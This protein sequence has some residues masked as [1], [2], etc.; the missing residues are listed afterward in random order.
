M[1]SDL[2]DILD[3]V[4]IPT[5]YKVGYMSNYYREPSFREIERALGLTRPE[6]L[7]LI[8]LCF[9]DGITVTDICEFSGHLKANISR[10]AIALEKKALIDRRPHDGDQRRQ[11]L[12][13]TAAGR[14]LHDRF[15]PGLVQR[16]ADMLA[17]LTETERQQFDDILRKMCAHARDWNDSSVIN[18]SDP[19]SDG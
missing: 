3:A 19:A 13:V 14:A 2:N 15:M 11:L 8:F 5:S 1:S 4:A 17:C 10:A 7:S 6:I 16:E 18:P 9:R 12:F